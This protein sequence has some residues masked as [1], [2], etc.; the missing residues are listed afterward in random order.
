[1]GQANFHQAQ[2]AEPEPRQSAP[3]A[4]AMVERDQAQA[5]QASPPAEHATLLNTIAATES[6]TA[7]AILSHGRTAAYVYELMANALEL[8][9]KGIEQVLARTS[10]EARPACCAG[11]AF[12]CAIPVAVSAPEALYIAAYLQGTLSAEAQVDLCMYLRARV[13]ERQG[14]AVDAR[15]ARKRFCVFLGDD[16][17]CSIYPIRPLGCRGYNSM[18][19]AACEEA[20]TGQED[21]V[22]MHEGV[23]EV[24]AGVIYGLI[25]ASKELELEWGRY[26][27]EGAVLRALDTPEAAERWARGEQVFAGCDQIAMLTHVAQRLQALNRVSGSQDASS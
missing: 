14:W 10:P 12:C 20:F 2:G 15:H 26:E 27:L 24:A 25:L 11:C 3:A 19:R 1:M 6:T 21:R 17:Q 18:S 23:R 13:E 4:N 8:A 9:Q 5:Q 7:A 22:Q 16:R